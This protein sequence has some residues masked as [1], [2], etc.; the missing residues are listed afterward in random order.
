MATVRK[1]RDKWQVQ[2]RRAGARP[3]SKS[4]TVKKDALAWA[5]QA[6]VQ[7][8]RAELP[9]DPKILHRETLGELVQR[10]NSQ[11]QTT[12]LQYDCVRAI[13]LSHHMR[14]PPY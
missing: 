11:L 4:F 1:R 2:I 6:E 13:A 14:R 8:D 12:V 7:A 10:Y 3:I 9:A 5:R